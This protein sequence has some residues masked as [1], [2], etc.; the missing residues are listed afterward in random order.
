VADNEGDLVR[1]GIDARFLTHPQ[2]G[3]F[4]TYTVNLIR[5]LSR[6]E[7]DHTYVIYVD[8]PA[9]EHTL[10]Q[11]DNFTYRVV[12]G[13]LPAFGMPVREQFSLRKSISKDKLDVVHF[14]CNTAPVG[15]SEKYVVTLHDTIQLTSAPPFKLR[16]NPAGHR[17]WAQFAYS[18]WAIM[19]SIASA[20]R[21]I[22]VSNYEKALITQ[23]LDI[24]P[25]RICVTHLAPDPEYV[26]FSAE[27]KLGLRQEVGSKY[28]LH[29]KYIL[30]VGYEDR[31]NIPL[32]IE[33]F[34]KVATQHPDIDLAIVAANDDK[35]DCFQHLVIEKRLVG[36]VTVLPA[37]T[38][39]D[40]AELY[41]LAELFVYPS[42]RESFGLPPVEAI[43]CG[44]TTLAMAATS[45]PEVLQDGAV[46]I[47]GN[48]PRIWADAVNGALSDREFCF[49]LSRR[50]LKRASMLNWQRCAQETLDVYNTVLKQGLLS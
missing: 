45:L 35:R 6:L 27:M 39:K 32:L 43:A 46:L 13:N 49:Q 2:V 17:R 48:D 44:T 47:D 11:N 41:N 31:K 28:G 18:K 24:A 12:E 16:Q 15:I 3:G 30:G 7:H 8:R 50:G 9:D 1:I 33:A 23:L 21:V 40:L 37:Q 10:P 22:T 14:L 36:R 5:E 29:N 38:P 4:K 34:S 19:R 42:E 20:A 25:Q 26:P